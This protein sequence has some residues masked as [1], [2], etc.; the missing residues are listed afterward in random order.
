MSNVTPTIIPTH[1]SNGVG[2]NTVGFN[3]ITKEVSVTLS[4]GF[5]TANSFPFAANDKVLVENVSVGVGT[6]GLGFN[7]VDYGYKL[8]EV[9]SVDENLG[10]IGTVYYNITDVLDGKPVGSI[11]GTYDAVNSA[12]RI[13]NQKDFPLFDSQLKTNEYF[14]GETVKSNSATGVVESWNPKSGLLKISS[15]ESFAVSETIEGESS[16]TQ[17]IA[18]SITSFVT[19]LNYDATSKVKHGWETDSGWLNYNLQRIQG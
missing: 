1:G 9:T 7:S 3:T 13:I 10:G 18:S 5:S 11:P 14:T 19:E 2:I 8:F 6:T 15:G 16:G 12:G 17:G 4:V